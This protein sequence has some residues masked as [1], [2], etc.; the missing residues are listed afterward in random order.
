MEIT[1]KNQAISIDAYV[2]QV[3]AQPKTEPAGEKDA[4]PQGLKTDTVVISDA[5][6]RIQ[7]AQKLIQAIPEVRADKVAE[8][9]NKI[10][11][12]T[13]EIKADEIAGKM[14]K[15]SLMNDLFK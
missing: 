13:Y 6:K 9:R 10:D 3:Q 1:N 7:E 4:Q 2:K 5:A 12:G 15:E 8:L 11:N 14:I